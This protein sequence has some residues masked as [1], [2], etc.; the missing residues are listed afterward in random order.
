MK[1]NIKQ[2]KIYKKK[3]E[4]QS[5][6]WRLPVRPAAETGPAHLHS[7]PVVFLLAR[8]TEA[9]RAPESPGH[10]LLTCSPLEAPEG[11]THSPRP[12]LTS[13]SLSGPPSPS[14]LCFPPPMTESRR[15]PRSQPPW[16]PATLRPSADSRS[17]EE[18][19]S[20]SQSS[21][22]TPGGPASPSTVVFNLRIRRPPP[23]NLRPQ[24]VPGYTELLPFTA[25]S[26]RFDSPSSPASPRP[27]GRSCTDAEAPPPHMLAAAAATHRPWH[28]HGHRWMRASEGLLP[29]PFAR[30]ACSLVHCNAALARSR[31]PAAASLA[32]ADTTVPPRTCHG[33]HPKRR[34]SR[35]RT[36]PAA[37]PLVAG[38]GQTR[39]ATASAYRRRLVAGLDDMARH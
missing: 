5:L 12:P 10:L 1:L 35:S 32:A 20:S 2:N 39:S 18:T 34:C 22:G 31:A 33:H 3:R 15:R 19:S 37:Q 9:W 25:V 8:R 23:V 30:L 16:P 29:V 36:P 4:A 26:A 27:L 13:P 38:D 14:L 24:R 21:Y 6:T 11:A 7:P 28:P 17:T